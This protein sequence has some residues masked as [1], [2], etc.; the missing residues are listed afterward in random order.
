MIY[1]LCRNTVEDFARWKAIFA[2]HDAAHLNAGLRLINTWRGIEHPNTV[3]F[4]FEV[5]S[6]HKARK[7][8][9]S[10]DSAEAAEGSG[11]IESDYQFVED[12]GGY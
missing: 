7:F 4:I 3:F 1:L 8:I 12:I 11:V 10:P 2:S 9:R 5:E 6:I